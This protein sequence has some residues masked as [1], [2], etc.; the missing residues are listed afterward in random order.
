MDATKVGLAGCLS[1]SLCVELCHALIELVLVLLVWVGLGHVY[2]A[3]YSEGLNHSP[4][5]LVELRRAV[6]ETFQDFDCFIRVVSK[7]QD[8]GDAQ[9][10]GECARKHFLGSRAAL[11]CL[12]SAVVFFDDS[13][14]DV[15][16]VVQLQS[17]W[18]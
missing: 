5:C 6:G 1:S 12:W 3:R 17:H 13:E 10:R 16:S 11:H 4:V 8:C 9:S 7:R 2:W 18:N 14:S 15:L